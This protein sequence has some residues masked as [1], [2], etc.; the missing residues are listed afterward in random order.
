MGAEVD[1]VAVRHAR[2]SRSFALCV[3]GRPAAYG[4]VSTG[5]EWIGE[6]RVEIRPPKGEAYVWNC[7]TL[8]EHRRRGMFGALLRQLATRLQ[9]EGLGRRWRRRA[10]PA[11]SRV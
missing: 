1:L 3:D 10:R 2:G 11:A 7:V 8:A 5:S 4:W 9:A 6:V